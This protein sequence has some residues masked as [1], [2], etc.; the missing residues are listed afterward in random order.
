MGDGEKESEGKPT[1][2]SHVDSMRVNGYLC[3]LLWERVV[4]SEWWGV[5]VAALEVEGG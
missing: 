3:S 1:P 2:G 4:L 5:V